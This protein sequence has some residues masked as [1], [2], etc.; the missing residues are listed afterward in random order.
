MEKRLLWIARTLGLIGVVMCVTSVAAR[1][2]G[3]YYV[4]SLQAGTLL[5]GGIAAMCV[6]SLAYLAVLVE[7]ERR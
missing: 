5:L 2:G 4:A 6:A 7:F 1:I 3:L